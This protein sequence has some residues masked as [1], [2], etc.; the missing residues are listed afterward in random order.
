[1]RTFVQHILLVLAVVVPA[2]ATA[3]TEPESS[4]T[5]VYAETATRLAPTGIMVFSGV[6]RRWKVA[7]GD[8]ALLRGRYLELGGA[9]GVNP[10]YSQG[11]AH[12]EWVPIAIL[13]LRLQYDLYG[14]F[15]ANGGLLSF[16]SAMSRFGD[17]EIKAAGGSEN[18]GLGQRLLFSPVLRA[19][20][21][22]VLLRS[23]TDVAWFALSSMSGWFYEAEYDTLVS[24][25]DL[26]VSN[27]TA[28]M[29]ELWRGAGE[30]TLLAGPAYE[31]THAFAADLGRQRAE[32]VVFW[33]PVETFGAFARPRLFAVGGMNL[34]DRNR[35]HDPFVIV[36]MGIDLDR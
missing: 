35:R 8:G 5:T 31:V 30:S 22:R 26:V 2:R 29:F 23:Q 20:A 10:A 36:G 34:V 11:G 7:D 18:T 9:V 17:D 27:R 12:L 25:S 24:H 6:L 19:R 1:M 13:Q 16:P 4:R 3:G 14:F 32:G 21:G 33:S 15:G 28:L